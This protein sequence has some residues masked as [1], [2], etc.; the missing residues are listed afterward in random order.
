MK[1]SWAGNEAAMVRLAHLRFHFISTQLIQLYVYASIFNSEH[2]LIPRCD[3]H[4]ERRGGS[5][6][7]WV[8]SWLCPQ[9]HLSDGIMECSHGYSQCCKNT[10]LPSDWLAGKRK[11]KQ[12]CLLSTILCCH[13]THLLMG[14]GMRLFQAKRG[15]YSRVQSCCGPCSM[16]C[17]KGLYPATPFKNI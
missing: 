17:L 5:S 8:L 11:K 9:Y 16:Q 4:V 6:D 14:L 3:L 12:D 15:L 7:I 1:H 13:Q 10:S 2:S